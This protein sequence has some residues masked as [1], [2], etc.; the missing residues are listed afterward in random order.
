MTSVAR[1]NVALSI[2]LTAFSDL[3]SILMTP[4]SFTLWGNFYINTL[5]D[6]ADPIH[7]PFFEVLKTITLL[8]ALP[9]LLGFLFKH[10]FPETTKKIFKP[11]KVISFIIFILFIIGAIAANFKYFADYFWLLLPIVFIHNLLALTTGFSFAKAMKLSLMNTKTIT[12]E[13]GIQNSGLA[14]VLIFNEGIFKGSLGGAA[15]I[16]AMWGIW[17]IVSGLTISTIWSYQ[18]EKKLESA[19]INKK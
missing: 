15:F 11:T 2:S 17:H 12:I 16:A 14:L 4:I 18:K 6:L 5:S 3:G 9:L 8:M 10:K 19:M 1:G 7:I 13:T